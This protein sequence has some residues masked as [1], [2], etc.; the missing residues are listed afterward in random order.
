MAMD[1]WRGLQDQWRKACYIT[2]KPTPTG[3]DTLL[4]PRSPRT[5][6][7]AERSS[8]STTAS[9][10]RKILQGECKIPGEKQKA[11]AAVVP[12]LADAMARDFNESIRL[13]HRCAFEAAVKGIS[14]RRKEDTKELKM[15]QPLSF[16]H[17][18]F[19]GCV[20]DTGE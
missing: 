19:D 20:L 12:Y 2:T 16:L 18:A 1:N 15:R 7:V 11:S 10:A 9:L 3:L 6:T 8:S 14:P 5:P 4:G 17:I 13:P